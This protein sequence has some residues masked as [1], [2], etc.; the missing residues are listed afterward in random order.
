MKMV[1]LL[2][3]VNVGGN[4]KVPMPQLCR[5]AD[6]LG[7]GSP[8]SYIN[9]GNLVFE[10]GR[11]TCA[12]V[13]AQ[14]EEA[15]EA[16]FGFHVDVIVRSSNQWASLIKGNPF[17]MAENR[18][19]KL[20]HLGLSKRKCSPNVESLLLEKAILGEK[21]TVLGSAIWIVFPGGVGKSKLTPV[22]F[23]RAAGSPVTLRNWNTVQKLDSMLRER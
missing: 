7:L 5:I 10:G 13:E 16:E 6:E 17:S 12:G 19:A 15:I 14:L 9:S 11:L 1:A 23:D 2:K 3:G 4:K 18:Q 8:R 21:V 20:L 22:L